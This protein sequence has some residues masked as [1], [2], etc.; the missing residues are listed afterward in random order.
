M[1]VSERICLRA[2]TFRYVVCV[3]EWWMDSWWR[4]R[5][6]HEVST[7]CKY[8]CMNVCSN[9]IFHCPFPLLFSFHTLLP[10]LYYF[11]LQIH[12]ISFYKKYINSR[13]NT[14][15]WLFN[16][17]TLALYFSRMKQYS[18]ADSLSHSTSSLTH[19]LC[20]WKNINTSPQLLCLCIWAYEYMYVFE[21]YSIMSSHAQTMVAIT[22][23]FLYKNWFWEN[24]M[25]F[26]Q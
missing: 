11:F 10:I 18:H 16:K 14:F 22:Y 19:N 3:C 21:I 6:F 1:Y 7:E 20:L 13:W 5:P 2:C 8:I 17:Q 4:E 26:I 15:L 12:N 25:C 24:L 9:N 23:F